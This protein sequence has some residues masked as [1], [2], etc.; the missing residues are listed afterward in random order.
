[1]CALFGGQGYKP[2]KVYVDDFLPVDGENSGNKALAVR[3]GIA[4]N[5]YTKTVADEHLYSQEVATGG[6][7]SGYITV[8]FD[9]ETVK[10]KRNLEM[11]IKMVENVGGGHS[12]G[13]GRALV[14]LEEV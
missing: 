9:N 2:S 12:K 10:Y 13:Y 14:Q 7:F 1:M 11:A 5:R 3:Y 8:Y 4:I 6:K